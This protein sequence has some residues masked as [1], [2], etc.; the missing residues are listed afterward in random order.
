[1][2][3]PNRL[4]CIADM[5]T[6]CTNLADIGTDHAFL[7]IYLLSENKIEFAVA[8]DINAGPLA[9]AR[10]NVK[11]HGKLNQV[12]LCLSDG[13]ENIE[14]NEVDTAVI[15][16]MGGETIAKILEVNIEKLFEDE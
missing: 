14:E 2:K 13:F 9:I 1:M 4:Q 15:A 8:A 12:R 10:Q 3:L 11:S 7:P 16:G 6:N 5:I